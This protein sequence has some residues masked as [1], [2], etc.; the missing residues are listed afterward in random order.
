MGLEALS[1]GAASAVFVEADRDAVRTIE[2][3]LDRL[4]LTARARVR[5]DAA[6]RRWRA[7]RGR[8]DLVLVDPPYETGRARAAARALPRHVLAPDGLSSS[9]PPRVEPALAARAADEPAIRFR[10]THAVRATMIT[11]IYPGTTTRSRSGTS[12]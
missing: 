4:Q 11:A 1:R 10:P 5:R 6:P 3:N 2:R 7:G 8:Y 9:R 12:T